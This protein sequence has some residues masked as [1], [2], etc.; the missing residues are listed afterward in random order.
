[1]GLAGF[2][3]N[4]YLAMQASQFCLV[5]NTLNALEQEVIRHRFDDVPPR[6][7][8]ALLGARSPM[9]I[10]AAY[11]LLRTWR[12]RAAQHP[13]HFDLCRPRSRDRQ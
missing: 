5:D 2:A 1:M 7:K 3:E 11:E 12:Q 9:W 4:P 13:D 10:Y 6:G 8:I